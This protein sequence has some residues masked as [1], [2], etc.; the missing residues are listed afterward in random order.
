MKI[1]AV[2]L[3]CTPKIRI[4]GGTNLL[5]INYIPDNVYSIIIQNIVSEDLLITTACSRSFSLSPGR[6]CSNT[7]HQT[8]LNKTTKPTKLTKLDCKIF[9]TKRNERFLEN[10]NYT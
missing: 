9:E 8:S 1:F 4:Q 7:V 10:V 3:N 5:K 6:Y 2:S